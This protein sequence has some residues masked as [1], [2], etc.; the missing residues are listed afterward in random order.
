MNV[1]KIIACTYLL[2]IYR[3]VLVLVCEILLVVIKIWK[4]SILRNLIILSSN[5]KSRMIP[6]ETL[7]FTWIPILYLVFPVPSLEKLSQHVTR[8]ESYMFSKPNGNRW[9]NW[10]YHTIILI[11]RVTNFHRIFQVCGLE[12]LNQ[13]TYSISSLGSIWSFFNQ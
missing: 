7:F 8:N 12:V 2:P 9:G 5:T 3:Y 4:I 13:W 1:W 10:K 11:L 6:E